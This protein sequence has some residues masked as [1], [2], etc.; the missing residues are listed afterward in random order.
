MF[1]L[2]KFFPFSRYKVVGH[3]MMPTLTPGQ[4]IITFNWAYFFAK[5]KVGD[6]VVVR[7][8]DKEMVKR[9][10]KVHNNEVFV[11]G[12]NEKDSLDSRKLGFIKIVDILGK[13]IYKLGQIQM[14]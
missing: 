1:L 14:L 13:V 6:I 10:Q 4:E 11:T 9:I 5:P 12:D 8:N 2:S 7:V 3:S